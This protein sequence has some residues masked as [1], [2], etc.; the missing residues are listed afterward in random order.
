MV[1]S[2]PAHAA[3]RPWS[4]RVMP[5]S[6]SGT[7]NVQG[8]RPQNWQMLQYQSDRFAKELVPVNT[9]LDVTILGGR[10]R[11]MPNPQCVVSRTVRFELGVDTVN[12]GKDLYVIYVYACNHM[13]IYVY[14]HAFATCMT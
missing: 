2:S 6:A 14:T 4:A 10:D 9:L 1:S 5:S 12:I 13:Y 3:L 11:L 8:P 7:V